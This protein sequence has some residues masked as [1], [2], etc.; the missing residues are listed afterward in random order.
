M[1][2]NYG[3]ILKQI[4]KNK[5][6]SQQDVC[7]DIISRQTLSSI[8]NCKSTPNYYTI[9]HIL[10]KI[11]VSFDEFSYI[12]NSYSLEEK[13]YLIEHFFYLFSLNDL[14]KDIKLERKCSQ[15]LHLEQDAFI[16]DIQKVLLARIHMK[17][18][19]ENTQAHAKQLFY[20]VWN[21]LSKMDN[22]YYNELRLLNTI[23]FYLPP[24][25]IGYLSKS[26]LSYLDRYRNFHKN[27]NIKADVLKNLSNLYLQK[28]DFTLCAIYSDKLLDY[29]K[30]EKRYDSLAIALT[31]LGI[32]KKDYNLIDN[33]YE[34]LKNVKDFSL[35]DELKKQ[36]AIYF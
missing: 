32:C 35:L 20:S 24:E 13:K 10:E 9:Y 33:A 19:T 7:K 27:S 18:H 1:K 6:I 34:I 3:D 2:W 28:G 31:Y 8:E 30:E 36:V 22:W 11:N 14:D 4:R 12:C 5:N 29:S 16:Q 15:Y 17:K 23:I 25:S 21:R 26:L